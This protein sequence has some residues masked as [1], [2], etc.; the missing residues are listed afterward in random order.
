M[1]MLF[2]TFALCSSHTDCAAVG[3]IICRARCDSC[4]LSIKH[5]LSSFDGYTFRF[6]QL[7]EDKREMTK[8]IYLMGKTFGEESREHESIV[9]AVLK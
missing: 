7:A 6:Q 3:M 1:V 9:N 2:T 8:L 4:D 5:G